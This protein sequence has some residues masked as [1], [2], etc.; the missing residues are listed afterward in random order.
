VEIIKIVKTVFERFDHLDERNPPAR[1]VCE[2]L[3]ARLDWEG[4]LRS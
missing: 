2:V 1:F 4:K 3:L